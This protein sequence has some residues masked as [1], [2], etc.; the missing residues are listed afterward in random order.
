M[1]EKHAKK[2]GRGVALLGKLEQCPGRQ[3]PFSFRDLIQHIAERAGYM[4]LTLT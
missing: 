1:H 4:Q 3:N 2:G